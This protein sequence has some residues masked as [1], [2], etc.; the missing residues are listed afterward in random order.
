MN[1]VKNYILL[2]NIIAFIFCAHIGH[3]TTLSKNDEKPVTDDSALPSYFDDGFYQAQYADQL[4]AS[5]Q[6]PL[7]HFLS[8]A[9]TKDWNI[10]TDPNDW[11][12]TTLYLRAFPCESNPLK[13]FLN[14]PPLS[15]NDSAEVID[16]YT[17]ETEFTR[18]WLAV[19]ALIRLN[20]FKIHLHT[21]ADFNPEISKRFI[22]QQKRGVNVLPDNSSKKSFYQS[23]FL[24]RILDQSVYHKDKWWHR[25]ISAHDYPRPYLMHRAYGYIEIGEWHKRLLNPLR[26]NFL[27][28]VEEPFLYA[29]YPY[30]STKQYKEYIKRISKGFDLV[31]FPIIF[32][33]NTK[34]IP[35]Y[36]Q[37][38]IDVNTLKINKEFSISNL[39]ST[40]LNGDGTNFNNPEFLYQ[41]R[42]LIWN[43]EKSLEKPTRFYVSKRDIEKYPQEYQS[44]VL[45]TDTKK[46]IFDSQFNIAIE[47]CRQVN[48]MTEKLLGCFVSLTIPIYLGCP[49]VRDYFDERGMFIAETV[50]DIISMAQSI[51]PDTYEKM[52]PYLQENKKRAEALMEL[53]SKYKAEFFERM[54]P[55]VKG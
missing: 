8:I 50:E 21:P 38:W 29:S 7:D 35:G 52:L 28:A 53:E 31:F 25:A 22:P 41:V 13:N 10:H 34:V 18:T 19:E 26:V 2:L 3:S 43:A 44:R 6:K 17:T 32:G 23:P 16:V 37:S 5:G 45:P 40:S 54:V 30:F 27:H 15:I 9:F 11:F 24:D 36:M 39:L 48:Y 1:K 20:Q 33:E 42:A 46:W 47:N 14:Q 4:K 51:Q 49:N 12:N 55:L